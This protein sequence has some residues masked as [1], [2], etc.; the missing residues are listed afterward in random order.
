[1]TE[2]PNQVSQ[3]LLEAELQRDTELE[4]QGQNPWRITKYKVIKKWDMGDA[5]VLDSAKE[6]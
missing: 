4:K 1:M 2:I 5:T 3:G 6:Q